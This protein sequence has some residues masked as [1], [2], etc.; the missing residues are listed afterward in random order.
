[1]QTAN[2]GIMAN[3]QKL[4]SPI[5]PQWVTMSCSSLGTPSAYYRTN[6]LKQTT[7]IYLSYISQK[8]P[9][10][11]SVADILVTISGLYPYTSLLHSV[12]YVIG[13][14]LLHLVVYILIT[15]L[16]H[17]KVY[18]LVTSLLHSRVYILDTFKGLHPYYIQWFISLLNPCY[19]KWL[20]SLLHPFY[21][22]YAVYILVTTLLHSVVHI[23]VTSLLNVILKKSPCSHR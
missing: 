11:H 2:Y 21:N 17:S 9:T 12:L 8:L 16:L 23:L 6:V 14:S 15:S 13:I 1:M 3:N 19:I 10:G 20:I 7:H 22:Q 4:L 5:Q 18:A